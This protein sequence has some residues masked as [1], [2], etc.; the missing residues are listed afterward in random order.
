MNDAD[1]VTGLAR[2]AQILDGC[3]ARWVVGGSTGLA[4]RGAQL[5]R[6]PRDLDIYA[7]ESS[8]WKIHDRL[9]ADV[10]DGPVWSETERYKSM[11][12]HYRLDSITVELVGQ[13]QV[14]ALDSR[15]VTEVDAVLFPLA[16]RVE[17]HTGVVQLIPLGHELI[18]NLLRER[19]DRAT[20][21]ARLIA[22]H[23]ERHMPIMQQ[24]IAR[25][26]LSEQV[27]NAAL[28]LVAAAQ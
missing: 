20:A 4:L 11:L 9:Q 16:D 12:S 18:F 24:L 28:R 10:I 1:S 13:F 25:N 15:Y 5:D 14:E 21:A 22:S 2:L 27:V 8:V 17:L 3:G 26:V 7:D 23:P 6:A 19:E